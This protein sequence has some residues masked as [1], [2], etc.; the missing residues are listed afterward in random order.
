MR[1]LLVLALVLPA[2]LARAQVADPPPVDVAVEPPPVVEPPLP[3]PTPPPPPPDL[4]KLPLG[5]GLPL[6]VQVGVYFAAVDDVDNSEQTWQGTIDVRLRWEDPRLRFPKTDVPG[7]VIELRNSAAQAR[8]AE[9]WTPE[10]R[11]DNLLE[12]RAVRQGVFISWKGEVE[13]VTRTTGT[14]S[15]PMDMSKFPFDRQQ[16]RVELL[17]ER[18][19]LDRMVLDYR[20]DDLDFSRLA[21]TV[22]LDGWNTGSVVL[23]RDPV[24]SWRGTRL[25]RVYASLEVTRKPGKSL[26]AIFI[27]LLASLLIPMLA[28][29]LERVEDGEVKIEAFELANVIIGGLFAVIALN[30]TIS[31][32]WPTLAESD[33]TVTRLL[34]LNYVTLGLAIVLNLTVFRFDLVRRW[35]GRYVQDQLFRFLIWGLPV[36]VF[37]TAAAF[38]FASMA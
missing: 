1:A 6:L 5:K 35:F 20:Q 38:V 14:F 21:K 16:L 36:M 30:F 15:S 9:M 10:I 18:E 13:L 12:E 17:S 23:S 8:L 26:A 29:W 37:S 2:S 19:D 3:P 4:M 28:M 33:N 11:I 25:A 24:P 34:A 27:P 32:E 31:S 7:G 22:E